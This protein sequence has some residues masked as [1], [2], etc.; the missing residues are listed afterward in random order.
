MIRLQSGVPLV[1]VERNGVIESIHRGHL[2]VLDPAGQVRYTAGQPDQPVF[3]RSSLKPLQAVAMVRAGLDATPAELAL[4]AASHSGSASHRDL[5][6]TE[7]SEAGLSPQD[8]ECP[9][10][11]PLGEAER[12]AY[13]VSGAVES[14]LAMNCSGKHTAMLRTCLVNNWPMSGYLSAGHPLQLRIRDEV[15]ELAGEPVAATGVDGCG[16]PLFALSLTAIARAFARIATSREG[17]ERRVAEAM[18]ARPELVGGAGRSATLLMQGVGGLIAK[19]GAEGIYAAALPDGGALAL[20]IDDGAA[21]A[22]D[23]AVV[24]GLRHLGVTAEILD[25]LESAP[26][27]GG[28]IT[29]GV[30]RP[31]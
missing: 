31:I 27:L 30:V 6:A 24:A 13:L 11:L 28:G 15:A 22:A 19:D 1:E 20:K 21:R 23:R 3:G 8:L 17:A 9:A 25:E 4:A 29:V 12:R 26:V 16:A 5:I 7:L 14:R 2:I 10:D 18:R